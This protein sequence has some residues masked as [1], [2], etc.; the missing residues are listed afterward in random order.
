M[1]EHNPGLSTAAPAVHS[2]ASFGQALQ[3]AATSANTL[4]ARQMSWCDADFAEWPLDDRSLLE[5]LTTWLQLPQRRLVLLAHGYDTMARTHPRFVEWRRHWGHAVEPHALAEDEGLVLPTTV[6]VDRELSVEVMDR[7]HWRG[8]AS[9]DTRQ[10]QL[11]LGQFDALVQ[12]SSPD[13][14]VTRLGL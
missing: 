11:L 10:A 3:W 4:G 13:F 1:S 9:R 5:Q 2:R 12:R 14:P 6:L 7:L 8:R